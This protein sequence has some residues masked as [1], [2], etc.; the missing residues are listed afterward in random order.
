MAYP[1]FPVFFHVFAAQMRQEGIDVPAGLLPSAGSIRRHL[2]PSVAAMRHTPAGIEFVSRQTIPGN[3][4]AST[5]AIQIG[6]LV[7]AVQKV[8]EAAARVQS[9]N[10]LHQI[11]IAMHNYLSSNGTFPPAYRAGKDGKALLSWRVLILP[12]IDQEALYNEFHLD[13]PWDSEHNK[14]LI[15]RMPK[16]YRSP[17]SNAAPGMTNYLTVRGPKTAFP[18]DKGVKISEIT[19]GTS[20]TIMAV[21]VSD[22]KAVIWTKPDDIEFNE[23]NPADGLVGLWAQGFQAAFCDGSVRFLPVSIKPQVLLDL[24]IRDDGHPIPPD[25]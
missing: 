1:F 4:G 19:D 22:N 23:K 11:A 12:Y 13:E 9:G 17:A 25:F 14:K 18:G 3:M 15:E 2:R 16:V 24:F 20:N 8:R 10:N 7:P 5:V 6:L 21:E